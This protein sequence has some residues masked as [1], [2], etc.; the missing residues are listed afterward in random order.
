MAWPHYFKYLKAA[1]QKWREDHAP[2]ESD[3]T[4]A[5]AAPPDATASTWRRDLN[6]FFQWAAGFITSTAGRS[7]QLAGTPPRGDPPDTAPR[8]AR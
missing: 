3:F 2:S 5:C 7:P 8:R 4:L 1:E 6:D